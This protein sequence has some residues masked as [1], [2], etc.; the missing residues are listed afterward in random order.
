MNCDELRDQYEL[1]ALGALEP[2]E[3]AELD[4]HLGREGDPCIDG[5]R[6]ARQ[7]MT[8]LALMT[9]ESQPPARLRKRVVSL[10]V[11]PKRTWFRAPEWI[12]ATIAMAIIAGWLA[13][14]R[15][16]QARALTELRLE[17]QRNNVELGRLTEAFA[18]MNDPAAKQV[19]FGEGAPKPPRGRVFVNPNRGVLLLASNLPPAPSGK[20][21]EM[22]IIP[23]VG[24]PLPAGLFQSEADGTAMYVRKGPVDIASTGVIAVTL[25]PETGSQ[26]PTTQPLI[27]AAL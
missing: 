17:A 3:R 16:D 12:A 9:P 13:N 7:T 14:S 25:E 21:Y 26:A 8:S 11:E 2:E 22:W 10:V 23:K 5:V 27:A 24:A 18:L 20:I 19:V 1:Y 6:H 15:R 4:E